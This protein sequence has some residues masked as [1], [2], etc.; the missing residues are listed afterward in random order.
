MSTSSMSSGRAI[1]LVVLRGPGQGAVDV[2]AGSTKLGRVSLAASRWSRD[3]VIVTGRAFT[4][5]FIEVKLVTDAPARIDALA[6]L[7]V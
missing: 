7:H 4:N 3:T 2:Y 1:G 6:V 5:Q